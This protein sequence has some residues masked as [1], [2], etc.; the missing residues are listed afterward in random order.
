MEKSNSDKDKT[1]NKI[2]NEEEIVTNQIKIKKNS[3][4]EQKSNKK[5]H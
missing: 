5:Q 1:E 4:M 3:T 2:E